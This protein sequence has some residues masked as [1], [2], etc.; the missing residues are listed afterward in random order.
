MQIPLQP[1]LQQQ[2]K[3]KQGLQQF[4]LNTLG[5]AGLR[6]LARQIDIAAGALHAALLDDALPR[7]ALAVFALGEM[8]GLSAAAA[9][10]Q[11]LGLQVR[12]GGRVFW[13]PRIE[14]DLQASVHS[15]AATG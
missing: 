15:T 6:R 10:L 12:L 14:S 5:E 9:G 4:L 3:T 1:S 8:R 13:L 2:Q 7:L 11:Q